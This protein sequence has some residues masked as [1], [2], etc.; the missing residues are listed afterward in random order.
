MDRPAQVLRGAMFQV[1]G[2]MAAKLDEVAVWVAQV[3]ALHLAQGPMPGY[4][5]VFDGIAHG[6]NLAF[7]LREFA[8]HPQAE[9]KASWRVPLCSREK[10]CR[11]RGEVELLVSK[12]QR[13]TPVGLLV[14]Q[15]EHV[16]AERQTG[17]QVA[18]GYTR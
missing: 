6:L 9:V 13:M 1:L 15:A 11:P 7:R 8:S 12:A 14:R 2:F 3:E 5:P 4:R 10:L 16:R 18:G 17:V